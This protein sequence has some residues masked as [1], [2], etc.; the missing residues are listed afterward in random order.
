MQ[1]WG[2]SGRG[3]AIFPGTGRGWSISGMV[4]WGTSALGL[5]APIAAPADRAPC[6]ARGAHRSLASEFARWRV[7]Y[8][9]NSPYAPQTALR[10]TKQRNN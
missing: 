6:P 10:V 3:D 5:A 9:H 2:W 8:D 1:T 7:N 4:N